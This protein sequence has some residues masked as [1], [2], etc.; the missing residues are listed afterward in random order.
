M[1]INDWANAQE[2]DEYECLNCGRTLPTASDDTEVCKECCDHENVRSEL[3]G[4]YCED[5]GA[6]V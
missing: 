6:K 4:N 1:T 2:L 3:T 5:C